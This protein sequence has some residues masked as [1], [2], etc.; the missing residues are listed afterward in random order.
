MAHKLGYP[1]PA[2]VHAKFF[3]ALQGSQSKM[4]AS[5]DT[6][7]IFM[8]DTP[9]QIK[10]K[11]NKYAF[12]GGQDT[13]ELHRERGGDPDVD[14]SYQ[15]LH[16]FLDDDEELQR[17]HDTYKSGE[18]LT[19]NLK[20]KCIEVLTQLCTEFQARKAQ[21]TLEVVQQFMDASKPMPWAVERG[22]IKA[23][24]GVA[25]AFELLSLAATN[26]SGKGGK[27]KKAAKKPAASS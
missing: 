19:G 15:Y 9:K 1:K 8:S 5:V 10:T 23:E 17:L 12:S 20:A 14:V 22:Q 26:S 21:V 24:D 7:A 11:I 16:F 13:V 3:P 4:S 25:S 2:L 18:L 27:G 6:S